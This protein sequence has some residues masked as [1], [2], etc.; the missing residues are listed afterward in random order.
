MIKYMR[1]VYQILNLTYI[2]VSVGVLVEKK[3]L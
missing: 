1:K 2:D 3:V